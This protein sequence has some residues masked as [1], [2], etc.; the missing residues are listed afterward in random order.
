[1]PSVVDAA[2]RD[3]RI[4]QIRR[5]AVDVFGARGFRGTSMAAIADAV[6]ISRPALSQ[7]FENRED[8][9][10]AAMELLLEASADR[11]LAAL[12]AADGVVA[13]LSGWVRSAHLDGYASLPASP[14]RP[15]CSKPTTPSR[16]T[17][18]TERRRGCEP[19]SRRTSRRFRAWAP[20]RS[21]GAG[22]V[23]ARALRP[24]SDG[25]SPELYGER[26]DHLAVAIAA[27]LHGT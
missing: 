15:S 25:P 16:A 8:V 14:M 13:A 27:A 10:R 11:A 24:N 7:Y 9:F 21:R 23:D 4:E 26:L 18:R 17:S 20:P 12:D 19:G 22:A 5:A 3:E 6:G 1:M 2:S